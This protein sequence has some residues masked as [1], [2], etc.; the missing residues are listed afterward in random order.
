MLLNI[1]KE[2]DTYPQ[3]QVLIPPVNPYYLCRANAPT[4]HRTYAPGYLTPTSPAQTYGTG[5]N[6]LMHQK[7][8]LIQTKILMLDCDIKHRYTLKSQN[9][10]EIALNQCTCRNL[11]YLIGEQVLDKR[12]IELERKILDLERERRQEQVGYFRDILFLKKELR[13]TLIE[14]LEEQQKASIFTNQEGIFP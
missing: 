14:Q 2:E 13:D 7:E 8:Q 9:L 11:I 4:V 3:L 12:R 10:Y 5:L 1:T 6:D